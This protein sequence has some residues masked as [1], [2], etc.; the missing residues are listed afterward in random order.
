MG[1]PG[2]KALV[3]GGRD[4]QD[5]LFVWNYLDGYGPPEITE[6][7]SGM[8]KGVDTFAS[9]WALKYGFKLHMFPADWKKHGKS[10][11]MIRNREMLVKGKPD[12][13]IAFPGGIGTLGMIKLAEKAGVKV[14][15]V[16]W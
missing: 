12:I 3:C 9:E 13:V 5:K 4:Y 2:L 8:A 11:G 15:K 1:T 6:I 10:A 7:V 14:I 16:G